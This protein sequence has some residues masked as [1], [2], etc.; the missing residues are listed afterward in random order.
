MVEG[1]L[2]QADGIR[3]YIGSDPR[4]PFVADGNFGDL[5]RANG[6]NLGHIFCGDFLLRFAF[7]RAVALFDTTVQAGQEYSILMAQDLTVSH[8]VPLKR[9]PYFFEGFFADDPNA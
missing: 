2:K 4:P 7:V 1:S 6:I 9:S 8:S 3:Q 5:Y